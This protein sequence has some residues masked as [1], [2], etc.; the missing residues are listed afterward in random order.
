MRSKPISLASRSLRAITCAKAAC[1]S[2]EVPVPRHRP[3]L[4]PSPLARALPATS[5]ST[6]Q[7]SWV[8][9]PSSQ[10]CYSLSCR[11]FLVH[12]EIVNGPLPIWRT[13]WFSCLHDGS[14]GVERRF[15]H[16]DKCASDASFR[17][18]IHTRL[19]C[20]VRKSWRLDCLA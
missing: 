13:P 7:Q 1:P 4:L 3:R 2:Q 11:I 18:E 6:S 8:A 5:R 14:L 16:L 15:I 19:R 20:E 12:C 9:H 17:S 10:G